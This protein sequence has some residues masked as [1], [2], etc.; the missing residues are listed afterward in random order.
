MMAVEVLQLS[1]EIHCTIEPCPIDY[2]SSDAKRAT[3]LTAFKGEEKFCTWD[4]YLNDDTRYTLYFEA[5][6]PFRQNL[7]MEMLKTF[8]PGAL[9]RFDRPNVVWPVSYTHLTLPTKR[10]V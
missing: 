8:Y 5:E 7:W 1:D 2:F 3:R 6:E 4:V 10:I 9:S